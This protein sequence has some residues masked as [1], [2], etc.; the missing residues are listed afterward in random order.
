MDIFNSI[1]LDCSYLFPLELLK[2]SQQLKLLNS[3]FKFNLSERRLINKGEFIKPAHK[4]DRY[5][6]LFKDG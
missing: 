4:H 2:E 3:S 1:A 5:Y 6:S